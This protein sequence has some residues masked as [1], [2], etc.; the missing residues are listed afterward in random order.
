MIWWSKKNDHDLVKDAQKWS[1]QSCPKLMRPLSENDQKMIICGQKWSDHKLLASDCV[2]T[3]RRLDFSK[4]L[5]FLDLPLAR[6]LIIANQQPHRHQHQKMSTQSVSKF[7]FHKRHGRARGGDKVV[8]GGRSNPWQRYPVC[9]QLTGSLGK[10]PLCFQVT[11][12]LA[13]VPTVLSND[14]IYGKVPP[15]ESSDWI[16]GLPDSISIQANHPA[17]SI[18]RGPTYQCAKRVLYLLTLIIAI[19]ST[20][21]VFIRP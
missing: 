8:G 15:V 7:N 21:S 14:W 4:N 19:I 12:S 10:C 9:F 3:G 11:G 13:K 6:H 17:A 2:H 16:Y 18:R 5:D 1:D 20:S